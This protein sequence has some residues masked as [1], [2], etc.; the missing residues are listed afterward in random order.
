VRR[1]AS[2]LTDAGALLLAV[3]GA[4]TLAA[5]RVDGVGRAVLATGAV[6]FGASVP[7]QFAADGHLSRAVWWRNAPTRGPDAWHHDAPDGGS[8]R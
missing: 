2:T 8:S 6:A 3:G 7:L 5:G 1:V 4:R